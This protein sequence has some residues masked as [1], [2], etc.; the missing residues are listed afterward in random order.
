MMI[1]AQN[2]VVAEG[3]VLGPRR[4]VDFAG[5]TPL[6]R[7]LDPVD[8]LLHPR[9]ALAAARE[10]TLWVLPRQNARITA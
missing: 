4:P 10:A 1:K 3:T 7:H 6:Q 5:A 9:R 2:A 8:D